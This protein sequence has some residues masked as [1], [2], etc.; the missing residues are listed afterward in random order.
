MSA[1]FTPSRNTKLC[2]E[3]LADPQN[4]AMRSTMSG[5]S[6]PQWN[7]CSPPID[8]P[9]TS[10]ILLTPNFSVT[11]R[12]CCTTLSNAVTCGNRAALYGSG[13]LLGDDD[14]PLPNMLGMMMKYLSGSNA[15]PRPIS[16]SLS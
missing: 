3:H 4:G 8:Q 7:V 5:N 11:R 13:V 10:L 9:V 6:A 15:R 2:R 12:C 16:H 14:R 1:A